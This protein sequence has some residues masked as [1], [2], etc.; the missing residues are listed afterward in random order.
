MCVLPSYFSVK[1]LFFRFFCSVPHNT[2]TVQKNKIKEVSNY[3]ILGKERCLQ[4]IIRTSNLFHAVNFL[5]LCSCNY[6]KFLVTLLFG[7][8]VLIFR[9]FILVRAW[10]LCH[11]SISYGSVADFCGRWQIFSPSTFALLLTQF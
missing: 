5:K 6:F 4:T 9:H 1:K 3:L 11:L 2:V 8:I 10:Q 7:C